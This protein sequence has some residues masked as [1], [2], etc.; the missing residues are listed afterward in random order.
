MSQ[1]RQ[2]P[3]VARK[4]GSAFIRALKWCRSLLLRAIEWLRRPATALRRARVPVVVTGLI[5]LSFSLGYMNGLKTIDR[6]PQPVSGVEEDGEPPLEARSPDN[7]LRQAS[8]TDAQ[9]AVGTAAL[10]IDG[11]V[12]FGP[13][14]VKDSQTGDWI[15]S[16]DTVMEST[17]SGTVR[18]A[19]PGVV[20]SVLNDGDTW[21]VSVD[22]GDGRIVSYSELAAA[23]VGPGITVARGQ[24][25][26]LASESSSGFRVKL[27]A[28]LNGDPYSVLDL[29]R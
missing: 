5:V 20:R 22:H 28:T 13:D 15:Y 16:Y 6:I 23:D 1:L 21:T 2:L 17:N 4:G 25:I 27:H 14:W 18:S 11:S 26:G 7:D 9:A 12:V 10:P 19:L 3:S 29:I 24:R 8:S